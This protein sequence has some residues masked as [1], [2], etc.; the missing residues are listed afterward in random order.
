MKN[1]YCIAN[2]KMNK[3]SDE[4]I[5]FLRTFIMKELDRNGIEIIIC[6]SYPSL[7][8]ADKIIFNHNIQ[9]GAQ[10]VSAHEIGAHTGEI[11]AS[12]LKDSNCNWVIVGHSER[13]TI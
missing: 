1:K 7:F 9:L 2:W 12:M 6:P 4:T 13:R 11:S 8:A 5:K 3:T 10:N